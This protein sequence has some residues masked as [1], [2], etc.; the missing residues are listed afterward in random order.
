MRVADH[1][2]CA[3]TFDSKMNN[4]IVLPAKSDSDVMFC[5][6]SYQWLIIDRSLVYYR[7]ALAQVNVL[8]NNCKQISTSLSLLAG[9]TVDA[10]YDILV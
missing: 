10:V 5:L 8:L 1:V 2:D 6:Q 9:W 7:L 4:N 3:F